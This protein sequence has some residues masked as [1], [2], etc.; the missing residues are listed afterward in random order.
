MKCK[1]NYSKWRSRKLLLMTALFLEAGL[2]KF[3]GKI[4]DTVWLIA[5]CVGTF[6]FIVVRA[7]LDSKHIDTPGSAE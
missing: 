3:L 1:N 6:G 7:W 2:F 5:S 4:G